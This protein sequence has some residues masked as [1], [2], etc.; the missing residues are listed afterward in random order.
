MPTDNNNLPERFDELVRQMGDHIGPFPPGGIDGFLSHFV[1]AMQFLRGPMAGRAIT[2]KMPPASQTVSRSSPFIYQGAAANHRVEIPLPTGCT[3]P[4][5][6]SER[7]FLERPAN[8]F[9]EGKETVWMQILNLDARMNTTEIGPIRIIL[10]ET[11][12]REYGDIF[13]PSHG[14]AQSLGKNGFPARLFFNPYAVIETQMGAMRAIHGTLAYGRITS[15][16]PVGTPVSISDMVPLEAVED[17]RAAQ[18]GGNQRALGAA[19]Q[20]VQPVA[21]IYALSHPIDVAM[22]VSGDEA[23]QIVERAIAL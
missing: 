6:I 13:R 8:Y 21:K 12:K 19:L 2:L 10:G 23:F 20:N 4:N 18:A 15:F 1:I 7:D 11:L 22:Q 17:V 3:L 5:A 14:V 16:P 9:E